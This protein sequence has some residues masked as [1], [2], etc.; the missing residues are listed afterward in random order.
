MQTYPAI[1]LAGSIPFA[2]I[3]A[4]GDKYVPADEARKLFGPNSSTRR[5]YEVDARSHGFGGGRPELL[6]DL[7]DALSWIEESARHG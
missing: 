3:Q 4:E 2:V 1:R 7:D 5:L 6:R